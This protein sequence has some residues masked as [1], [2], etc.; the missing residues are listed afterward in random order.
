[1]AKKFYAIKEG[2]NS[3]T[4]EKVENKIVNTWAECLKYVKGI[5]GAKYKSFED[6]NSAKKFLNEGS[7]MLKKGQDSYPEDCL[8]IYVDGSYNINTEKY[9]YG[10]VAVLNDIVLY[11]ES[12]ASKDNAKKNIRQ[13]AGELEGAIRGVEYSLSRGDKKVVIFHDYE[14]VSHHA[15]GFWERKESS[16]IEYYT[17]M[18][19]LISQGIEVIFV[20][21]DSH[22]GDLFNE[23]VDEKCKEKLSIQSDKSTEKW[24]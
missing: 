11:I 4:G 8:H 2:F 5:K 17:K 24:L 15:T 12:N 21:V 20:K 16:S 22:Q 18:N 3:E 9:A 1:M 23:L 7:K 19:K 14:G 13:I 10:M 6:I